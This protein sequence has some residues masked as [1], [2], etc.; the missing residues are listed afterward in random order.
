MLDL[1]WSLRSSKNSV[2][3]TLEEEAEAEAE[4]KKRGKPCTVLSLVVVLLSPSFHPSMFSS[5]HFINNQ[6][7]EEPP[8]V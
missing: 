4:K 2:V 8:S 5:I 3:D 1:I 7:K 6:L